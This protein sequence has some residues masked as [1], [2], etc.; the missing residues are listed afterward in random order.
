[1]SDDRAKVVQMRIRAD[2]AAIPFEAEVAE[3]N[4]R[5]KDIARSIRGF[6]RFGAS[7]NLHWCANDAEALSRCAAA[8]AESARRHGELRAQQFK[9]R[10]SIAAGKGGE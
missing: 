7:I 2:A 3:L 9:L 4:Q 8:L 6:R 5:M 1:M 10:E